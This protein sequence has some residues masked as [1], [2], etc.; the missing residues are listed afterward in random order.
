VIQEFPYRNGEKYTLRGEMQAF[1]RKGFQGWR[2]LTADELT[3]R[4]LAFCR[5]GF[6]YLRKVRIEDLLMQN[7]DGEKRRELFEELRQ[8]AACFLRLMAG[9][10]G[11]PK[12]IH[13]VGLEGPDRPLGRSL[14]DHN[15]LEDVI[16]V[17]SRDFHRISFCQFQHSLHLHWINGMGRLRDAYE[18][19]PEKRDLHTVEDIQALPEL[20]STPEG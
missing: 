10:E 16:P 18:R 3:E 20:G 1:A 4:V 19:S 2:S 15:L 14:R 11:D 9:P 8:R 5:E 13:F 17:S 6:S 12:R 7:S